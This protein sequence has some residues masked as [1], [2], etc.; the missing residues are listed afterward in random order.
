MTKKVEKRKTK[1]PI[2][3]TEKKQ[4][5][6]RG[7]PTKFNP[8]T[9]GKLV[10]IFRVDW[11]VE[12]ACAYAGIHKDT[13]YRWYNNLDGFSDEIGQKKWEEFVEEINRARAFLPIQA[14][15][16]LAK[17]ILKWDIKASIEFLKRR[18][19]DY[20]DKVE[21]QPSTIEDNPLLKRLYNLKNKWNTKSSQKKN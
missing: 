16:T 10:D 3:K 14:R 2:K 13:F 21:I 1:K 11:T 17:A 15:R 18:D 12:K 5:K 8:V 9:V 20:K 6:K 7:R 4:T 19:S